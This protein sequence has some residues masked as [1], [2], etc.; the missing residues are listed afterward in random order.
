MF[1]TI[2]TAHVQTLHTYHI[3][4]DQLSLAHK[5]KPLKAYVLVL[6]VTVNIDEIWN[7]KM[8]HSLY[9]RANSTNSTTTYTVS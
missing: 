6:T 9:G 3:I 2:L 1:T 7:S 5:I 4:H 8:T